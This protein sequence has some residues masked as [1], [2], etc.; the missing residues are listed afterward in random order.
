MGCHRHRAQRRR[1]RFSKPINRNKNIS[2]LKN[3]P[4]ERWPSSWFKRSKVMNKVKITFNKPLRRVAVMADVV[5]WCYGGGGSAGCRH[6]SKLINTNKM[7]LENP[8]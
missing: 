4:I 8:Y 7:E 6:C 1:R 2:S 3:Q 5:L